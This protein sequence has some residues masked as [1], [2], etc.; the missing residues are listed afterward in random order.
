MASLWQT[1]AYS[2]DTMGN[3]SS[4]S[5]SSGGTLRS[6]SFSYDGTK[7]KITS[8]TEQAPI[9]TRTVTYDAAG[10]E[11]QV[12][13]STNTFLYS[14]RNFLAAAAG[15]GAFA[16]EYDG[17]GVR[18]VSRANV[19]AITSL[20][21][22]SRA[23]GLGA[24][25][26]K[27]YG[28]K[29]TAASVVKWGAANRTT[30]FIS[31][32]ELNA[33][34]LASD[35][36]TAGT[37]TPI[38]VVDGATSNATNFV[39]DFSDE[40]N[41]DPFYPFVTIVAARGIT[42]GCG[43]TT[44]CPTTSIRRDQMAVFL[45]K[46]KE[47]ST[48]APP[49]CTGI[50]SDVTCP[51]TFTNWVEDAYTRGIM[52]NCGTSPLQFCPLTAVTRE[53]MAD[54]LL[55]G[56]EGASYVPPAA[57]GIFSDVPASNPHAGFIEE[58]AR[59]GITGGCG[60]ANYCPTN[61][62]TRAQ[63]ATFLTKTWGFTAYVTP[64]GSKR[65][66]L[67]SPELSLLAETEYATSY[68]PFIFYE[69][70]W[71]GGMPVAEVDTGTSTTHWTL[72]DHLGTPIMQTD[73]AAASYWRV[74]HEP[75]GRVWAKRPT[76]MADQHQIL[77]L[78]GQEAEQLT[79]N[80]ANGNSERSYNVFRWYRP[81]WGR[82]SQSDPLD[83][84]ESDFNNYRY[85]LDNPLAFTDILGLDVRVCCRPLRGLLLS[86]WKHCYLESNS[87]GTRRTSGLHRIS[88]FIPF[89]PLGIPIPNDRTDT[90]GTCETWRLDDSC[91]RL[92]SC[93][94]QASRQYPIERYSDV[95]ANLG[96][97]GGRNS[98]TFAKCVSR[99]CGI[100]TG[101]GVTEKAPGWQQPCPAGF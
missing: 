85:S 49:A 64:A 1:G 73:S 34:I 91:G 95:A 17:R 69:H 74:E 54:F 96:L 51:G 61:P 21:P 72:T 5:L 68:H 12:G 32:N 62:V 46:A 13:A 77:R 27:V 81:N 60:G 14:A 20:S 31:A 39:V 66:F 83:V 57:V 65:F 10:N 52:D 82:Y 8:V 70:F 98:N 94:D 88:I 80:T 42:A 29:F 99:K 7:P 101:M 97:F 53:S 38:T 87:G 33:A 9:G 15:D 28:S 84:S 75:Y 55:K 16:Y 78:P 67:Y 50:F 6:A 25:T 22:A 43:G 93:V 2:Y 79:G 63:M 35:V 30:T 4:V 37:L 47:G 76:G 100:S 19:L 40:P 23:A 92:A 36:S 26:L 45:L 59:R 44:F 18:T 41:T 89:A 56:L 24:F 71:F 86:N 11:V 58:L 90:G 3:V 48:Y